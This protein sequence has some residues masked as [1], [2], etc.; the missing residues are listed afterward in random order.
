MMEKFRYMSFDVKP[1]NFV[2]ILNGHGKYDYLPIDS[3]KIGKVGSN[4]IWTKEVVNF[5]SRF[6]EYYYEGRYVDWNG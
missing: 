6:G 5:K 3:K 1:D 4:I 2:K